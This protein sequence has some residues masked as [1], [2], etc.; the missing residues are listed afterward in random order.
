MTLPA[1]PV[2]RPLG[3]LGGTFDPVHYGHLRAA[4]EF[5]DRLGLSEVRLIPGAV[6]PHR[7]TPRVTAEGRLALVREGVGDTAGM[8][9]DDRELRRSSPS[10]TLETLRELRREQG[11]RP[12]CFGLGADAFSGLHRWYRWRELTDFAHLVVLERPGHEAAPAP[13]VAA[14]LANRRCAST[15]ALRERPAGRVLF[16]SVTALDVSATE[17]RRLLA[18]GRSARFLV[19]EGVWRRIAEEGWYGYPRL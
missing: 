7:A 15:D 3:V 10:Y 16:L 14:W 5:R 9:V 8:V 12:L 2:R 11:E 6:P 18:R 13:E 17:I 1:P 4:M 19:P